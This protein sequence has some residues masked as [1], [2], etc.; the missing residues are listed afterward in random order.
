MIDLSEI[1]RDDTISLVKEELLLREAGRRRD[2]DMIKIKNELISNSPLKTEIKRSL[3]LDIMDEAYA[4]ITPWNAES[5]TEE[6]VEVDEGDMLENFYYAAI[7]EFERNEAFIKE[8]DS[9]N[10]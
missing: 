8:R 7:E 9:D 4:K 2:V 5:R 1:T 3:S 6:D 10:E